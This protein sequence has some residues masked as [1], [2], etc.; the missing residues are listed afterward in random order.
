MRPEAL[1]PWIVNALHRSRFR[2]RS[3]H[4]ALE[5]TK[6]GRVVFRSGETWD[7]SI[8][9]LA[10]VPRY[11]SGTT[12]MSQYPLYEHDQSSDWYQANGP[13]HGYVQNDMQEFYRRI[14]AQIEA[15]NV[16]AN[17]SHLGSF[18]GL[19]QTGV[20]MEVRGHGYLCHHDMRTAQY[21]DTLSATAITSGLQVMSHSARVQ[22][23]PSDPVDGGKTPWR[24]RK[25]FCSVC[26]K[27]FG[28]PKD[29]DRHYVTHN[30][31]YRPFDCPIRDCNQAFKRKDHFTRHVRN[32]HGWTKER[33]GAFFSG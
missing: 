26:M 16:A 20:D 27:G 28:A 30:P 1:C 21:G 33:L 32:K 7:T 5:P 9:K 17:V 23:L 6:R 18:P 19:S 11:S 3:Y 13:G 24:E 25:Y 10:L 4:W 31:D 22:T 15:A 8:F 2:R 14:P 29:L 12:T